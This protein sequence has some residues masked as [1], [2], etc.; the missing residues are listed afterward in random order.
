MTVVEIDL[1]KCQVIGAVIYL[2]DH[3]MIYILYIYDLGKTNL[4]IY[5]N[6]AVQDRYWV[7]CAMCAKSVY[8][9][10]YILQS[11]FMSK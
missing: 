3:I 4:P 8:I 2:K 9:H 10:D 6:S 7:V 11:N 1:I 5:T